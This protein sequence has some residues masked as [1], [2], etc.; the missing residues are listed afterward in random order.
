MNHSPFG[1]SESGRSAPARR[2]RSDRRGQGPKW[3]PATG[4]VG[5][6]LVRGLAAAGH[7][8]VALVRSR[9]GA[10]R[11]LPAGVVP[12]RGDVTDPASLR[13]A[14]DGCD[15]VFHTAGLA[16]QWL[17][18]PSVFHRVNVQGTR[19]VVEAALP[20]G[21]PA[22]SCTS[23]ARAPVPMPRPHAPAWAGPPL[24]SPRGSESP[25]PLPDG[26]REGPVGT[27]RTR[28]AWPAVDRGPPGASPYRVRVG[29][30]RDF[31]AR[32]IRPLRPSP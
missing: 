16:E 31:Y 26:G 27:E 24:R 3:G 7:R 22:A 17:A 8:V 28:T 19:N 30:P 5:G 2:F 9:D 4:T 23:C 21:S 10:G 14:L 29:A 6:P 12:V 13:A 1:P 11:T 15:T 32:G 18:D 20:A 25:S